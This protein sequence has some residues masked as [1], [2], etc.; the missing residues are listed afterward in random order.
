MSLTVVL[1]VLG[2]L[3]T[4]AATLGSAIAIL[5]STALK[6][7]IDVQDG[8]IKALEKARD[9]DREQSVRAEQECA[10]RI[11]ALEGRSAGLESLVSHNI[12]ETVALAVVVALEQQRP[13]GRPTPRKRVGS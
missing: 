6:Q 7:T 4:I 5:R 10:Q 12:A 1:G 11:S 8:T 13:V 3:L 9:V 2:S